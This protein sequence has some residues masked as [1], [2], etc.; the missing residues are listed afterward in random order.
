MA[1]IPRFALYGSAQ[2]APAWGLSLNFEHIPER[3]SLFNWEIAPHVHEA[4]LQVLYVQRGGGVAVIEE[5]RYTLVPPCVIVV[6]AGHVHAFSFQREID[7]PVV[8]AAQRPLEELATALAPELLPVLRRP[9][10]LP[11]EPG[12]RPALALSPLF[13]ALETEAR[14]TGLGQ[15]AAGMSLLAAVMVQVARISAVEQQA[16]LDDGEDGMVG[17]GAHRSAP[18]SHPRSR[19]A[20]QI[21]R[22]KALVDQHFRERWPVQRYA[23]ELGLTAGQLARL[24]RAVLG[25]SPLEVVNA[26]IVHEAQRELIYASLGIKQVAAALGFDDDAYFG[27][28]FKKHTGLKPGAFRLAGRQVLAAGGSP[29]DT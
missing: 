28:F 25:T 13:A 16:A 9:A 2:P 14:T 26:R 12:S 10:V 6:P 17:G 19:P 21:E 24:T 18:R 3:S 15:V 22:F 1:T 23:H 4:L 29:T 8:T 5:R 20:R 7:G 27:R 11:V